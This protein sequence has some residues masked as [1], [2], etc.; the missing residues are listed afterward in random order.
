MMTQD[1]DSTAVQPLADNAQ[2]QKK[3]KAENGDHSV[4]VDAGKKLKTVGVDPKTLNWGSLGFGYVETNGHVKLTY[5]DGK[6]NEG[7]V[8]QEPY[9]NLHI[10]AT[11]LHYGQTCFEGLKAF[12]MKDGKIRLFRPEQNYRRMI[13]SCSRVLM[14]V[15]TLQ[16]FLSAIE[17]CIELNKEYVPPY[18]SGASLYVRPFLFGSG[19]KLGLSEADEYTF[20]VT[21]SPVGEYYSKGK[22]KPVK[23]VVADDFDRAAPLGVGSFKL[24][25]NYAPTLLPSKEWK[26]KGY[27][28]V[29]FLDP[30]TH[31]YVD[32][33]S[34][35]NFMAITKSNELIT[36]LSDSVLPSITRISLLELAPKLNLKPITRPIQYVELSESD[37]TEVAAVGTAVVVT[38]VWCIDR[39]KQS[40]DENGENKEQGMERTVVNYWRGKESMLEDDKEELSEDDTLFTKLADTL[41]GIQK[42]EV[43]DYFGW[44][45]PQNGL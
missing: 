41:K 42:G 37:V 29:L 36:P 5:K 4:A 8:I 10:G 24:A 18:G 3:R 32:E 11:V 27:P 13:R 14:P 26:A 45:W 23:A 22:V 12:R 35:S 16:Q 17:R 7:E 43:E 21:A 31:T 2:V 25:G 33:F 34:T 1:T 40:S 38:P 9:I 20:I 30:K 19:C 15:P 6:W 44:M 39:V 28:I